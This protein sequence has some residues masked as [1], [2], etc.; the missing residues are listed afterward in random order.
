M[1]NV[2]FPFSDIHFAFSGFMSFHLLHKPFFSRLGKSTQRERLVR[3]RRKKEIEKELKKQV[4]STFQ[5]VSLTATNVPDSKSPLSLDDNSNSL[6]ATK[7]YTQGTVVEDA[8]KTHNKARLSHIKSKASPLKDGTASFKTPP[9][10]PLLNT[11][12]GPPVGYVSPSFKHVDKHVNSYAIRPSTSYSQTHNSYDEELPLKNELPDRPHTVSS[13]RMSKSKTKKAQ[14]VK[15]LSTFGRANRSDQFRMYSVDCVYDVNYDAVDKR[16]KTGIPFNKHVDRTDM[17]EKTEGSNVMYNVNYD[18]LR[19]NISSPVLKKQHKPSTSLNPSSV[20]DAFY[21][22]DKAHNYLKPSKYVLE[23]D[24]I[25]TDADKKHTADHRPALDVDRATDLVRPRT[26]H[27]VDF[28]RMVKRKIP[29]E[30]D[31]LWEIRDTKEELQRPHTATFDFK[32]SL[33]RK[34]MEVSV[35]DNSIDYSDVLKHSNTFLE[36]RASSFALQPKRKPMFNPKSADFL[37]GRDVDKAVRKKVHTVMFKK[38]NK[39]FVGKN[40]I[41]HDLTYEHVSSFNKTQKKHVPLF[42]FESTITRDKFSMFE[43]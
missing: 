24:N 29:G 31:S 9:R 39:P 27:A 14:K 3:T 41:T 7:K 16:P 23:F 25:K 32:K 2:L 40:N 12:C 15:P 35:K 4:R 17:V 10:K 33:S 11:T 38:Q 6:A 19:K 18:V 37:P 8:I 28:T 20:V 22:T 13:R 43:Q 21:D 30:E 36:K 1:F 26:S 5:R 42:N 34:S